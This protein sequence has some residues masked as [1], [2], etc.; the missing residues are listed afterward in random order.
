[1]YVLNEN[2][3]N[4]LELM[5]SGAE[6]ELMELMRPTPNNIKTMARMPIFHRR[7]LKTFLKATKI[8]GIPQEPASLI[9]KVFGLS[10]C[11][12]QGIKSLI[13][14]TAGTMPFS[15]MVDRDRNRKLVTKTAS[16]IFKYSC[17]PFFIFIA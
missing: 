5:V 15:A 12:P 1:M 10:I 6:P 11:W 4:D 13:E 3:R 7:K 9:F 8:P 17:E 2:L 14:A 16:R